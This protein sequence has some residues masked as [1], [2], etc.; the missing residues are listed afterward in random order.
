[1]GLL[2]PW[3]VK[4]PD[5]LDSL[6]WS[7]SSLQQEERRCVCSSV[8]LSLPACLFLIVDW[9]HGSAAYLKNTSF[10]SWFN[11]AGVNRAGNQ[12]KKNEIKKKTTHTT[13]KTPASSLLS[14]F[15]IW[16]SKLKSGRVWEVPGPVKGREWSQVVESRCKRISGLLE[17]ALAGLQTL[18]LCAWPTFSPTTLK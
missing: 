17:P 6:V 16:V 13:S 11:S 12:N 1:M 18:L 15:F 14:H 5:D 3:G 8:P 2:I 10:L 9:W 4:L 7:D